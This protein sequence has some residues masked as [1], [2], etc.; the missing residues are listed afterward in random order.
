MLRH[1]DYQLFL[2]YDRDKVIGRIAVYVN[3]AYNDHWQEKTGFFGHYEC[4]QNTNASEKLLHTAESWLHDNDMERMQGQFNFVSQDIGFIS[5][6]FHIPPIVLSSYNPEY[7]NRQMAD[8][9]MKKAKDLLVYN[10]DISKGY[11]IPGRFLQFT[12]KISTRYNVTVRQIDVKNIV[13][14]ARIIVKLTNESLAGNWGFYPI[15]D[16]EAEQIAADLKMI[17]HPETVLIAETA[18]EP[19]AYLIALPDV[20]QIL[21]EL[22]GRLLSPKIFKLIFGIKKLRRY[23]IWALGVAKK[24]QRKGISVLL[25]RKLND[26]LAPRDAYVEANWV[27]EDNTLMNNAMKQLEFNLVKKYRIYEKEFK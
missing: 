21:K 14:D 12:D 13:R 4:I 20:N 23:R 8:F 11:T 7:Y 19:I 24:Y 5:E 2:L 3:L 10:C 16:E 1:C 25:F 27:L 18:G 6:G 26:P 9:G 22:N 17:V 15:K